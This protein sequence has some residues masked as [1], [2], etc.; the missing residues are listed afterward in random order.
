M[1]WILS[2]FLLW[3]NFFVSSAELSQPNNNINHIT[4]NRFYTRV[5][6]FHSRCSQPTIHILTHIHSTHLYVFASS[7]PQF[8][9]R[10]FFIHSIF[11]PPPH[12]TILSWVLD[13]MDPLPSLPLNSNAVDGVHSHSHFFGGFLFFFHTHTR[14]TYINF[15]LTHNQ[16]SHRSTWLN[17]L[18]ICSRTCI[19]TKYDMI[20]QC[21]QISKNIIYSRTFIYSYSNT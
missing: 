2:I 8:C 15:F 10:F 14:H 5:P 12:Y 18:L 7:H 6:V 3:F 17:Q 19:Y 16:T 21:Q 9:S 1:I 20:Y 13:F 4:F 11:S